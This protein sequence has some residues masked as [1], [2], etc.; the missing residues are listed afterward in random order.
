MILMF[1]RTSMVV[2]KIHNKVELK[3]TLLCETMKHVEPFFNVYQKLY[4][5]Q[6]P[7]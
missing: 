3:I 4:Y 7:R 5:S 2:M 6:P 1:T